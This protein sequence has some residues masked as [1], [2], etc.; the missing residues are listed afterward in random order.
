MAPGDS[1]CSE[2]KYPISRSH[3]GST[4]MPL[5]EALYIDLQTR[6]D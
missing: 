4:N 5:H 3:F 2:K 6:S 1:E